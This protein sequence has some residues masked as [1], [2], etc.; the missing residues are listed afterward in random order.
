MLRP[1]ALAYAAGL[2]LDDP[3]VSPLYANFTKGFPPTLVQ[4]GTK[5]IFLSGSARLYQKID[6]A[7]QPAFFD[8]V[9]GVHTISYPPPVCWLRSQCALRYV[10]IA[11][12]LNHSKASV[13]QR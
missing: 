9:G 11:R 12:Q 10:G 7:G 13:Q 1:S 2:P 3:R 5:T 8:E 4:E 6:E